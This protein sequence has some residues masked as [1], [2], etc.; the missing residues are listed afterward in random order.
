MDI[1]NDKIVYSESDIAEAISELAY[2]INNAI[3]VKYGVPIYICVMNG[4]VQFF[5]DI[6]KKLPPGRCVYIEASS[7]RDS[8]TAGKLIIQNLPTTL[9]G[10][11][12]FIFDDICDE[13]NTLKT[14]RDKVQSLYLDHDVYTVAFIDRLKPGKEVPYW[15]AIETSES[16][17]FAGY[18]MDDKGLC[19]NLPFI[20]DCTED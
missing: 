6:T 1:S 20:Y 4:A 9:K 5:A 19:R 10:G 18:G 3:N 11:Q 13:G 14:L 8:Q 16:T 7:Y 15:S 2:K 17:F 12:I